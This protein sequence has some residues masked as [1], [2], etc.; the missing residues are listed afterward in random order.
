M[1]PIL[2][3]SALALGIVGFA[4]TSY[5]Q[6]AST[7]ANRGIQSGNS[8][9]V[10]TGADA[11]MRTNM[12]GS[13]RGNLPAPRGNSQSDTSPTRAGYGAVSSP[14]GGTTLGGGGTGRSGIRSGTAPGSASTGMGDAG[15]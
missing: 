2:L 4:M 13:T 9:T 8:A 15:R 5:A 3:R 12:D 6:S 14:T 1:Y 7:A 10:G 11:G